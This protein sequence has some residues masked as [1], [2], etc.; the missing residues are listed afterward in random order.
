M[1]KMHMLSKITYVH[2]KTNLLVPR[3]S[4]GKSHSVLFYAFG[5]TPHSHGVPSLSK[6]QHH[7][8]IL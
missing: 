6:T 8:V 7:L 2:Q 1:I 3:P 5:H 4:H